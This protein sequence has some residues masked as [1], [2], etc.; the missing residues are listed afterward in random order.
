MDMDSVITAARKDLDDAQIQADFAAARVEELR[1]M[2]ATLESAAQR[3][4]SNRGTM[5]LHAEG[6]STASVEM[7]GGNPWPGYD[8][9]RAVELALEALG[10]ANSQEVL[11]LLS[12]K[13]R[14]GMDDA[15]SV[16]NSF[17]YLVRARR[18]VKLARGRFGPS[19][20]KIPAATGIFGSAPSDEEGGGAA[21]ETTTTSQTADHSDLQL[22][23]SA[24]SG[25]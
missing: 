11:S 6:W 14:S 20:A 10:D 16:R 7:S 4:A 12:S 3:Y 5:T 8:R 15:G 21:H 25:G 24:T 13:G 23:A 19:N 1:E 9:V 22:G 2:V 17:H 18:A